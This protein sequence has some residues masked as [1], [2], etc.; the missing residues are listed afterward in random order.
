M[1]FEDCALVRLALWGVV[2]GVGFFYIMKSCD[3]TQR[4]L[5]GT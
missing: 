4:E 3:A 5:T 1:K 2:S